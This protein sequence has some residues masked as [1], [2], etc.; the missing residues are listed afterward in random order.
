MSER[1]TVTIGASEYEIVWDGRATRSALAPVHDVPVMT[2]IPRMAMA[3]RLLVALVDGPLRCEELGRRLRT[4][5]NKLYRPL[6]AL[7]ASGQVSTEVLPA[8]RGRPA[9]RY[10]RVAA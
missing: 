6:K 9:V 2:R 7:I 5:P 8:T 10:Q 1:R 3:R 4:S